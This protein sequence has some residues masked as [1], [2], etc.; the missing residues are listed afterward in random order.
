MFSLSGRDIRTVILAQ[1]YG[2]NNDIVE[3]NTKDAF[4]D[5]DISDA[6][7]SR[8]SQMDGYVAIQDASENAGKSFFASKKEC[9]DGLK[10]EIIVN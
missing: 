4:D 5:C 6:N 1:C 2:E 8:E 9:R 7:V 10:L 3:F